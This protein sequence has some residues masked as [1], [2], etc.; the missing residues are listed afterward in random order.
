MVITVT[1]CRDHYVYI[2]SQWGMTLYIVTPRLSLTVYIHRMTPGLVIIGGLMFNFTGRENV[3]WTFW[4]ARNIWFNKLR[5]ADLLYIES[6]WPPASHGFVPVKLRWIIVLHNLV[7][8]V[9]W[10]CDVDHCLVGASNREEIKPHWN[11]PRPHTF[12]SVLI[13]EGH[14]PISKLPH[15]WLWKRSKATVLVFWI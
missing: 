10:H 1:S 2:P 7:H 4:Y 3:S 9:S 5:T 14:V 6:I 12:V 15:Y 13:H 11:A 8:G